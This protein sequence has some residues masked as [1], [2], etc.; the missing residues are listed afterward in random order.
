MDAA[1]DVLY[2]ALGDTVNVA[3]RLQTFAGTG[4]VAIGPGTARQVEAQFELEP[5]GELEL[6]GKSAPVAAFRAKG[7][8]EVVTS[9]RGSLLVG[10]ESELEVF[11]ETLE[12]L[13]DGRGGLVSITGEPGSASRAWWPRYASATATGLASSRARASRTRRHFRT[14]RSASCCGAGSAWARLLRRREP[15]SS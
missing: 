12:S 6:K 1:A 13:L 11:H 15:G 3:A 10:R 5:L 9:R 8:R 2:N 14:G 7:S 4:G